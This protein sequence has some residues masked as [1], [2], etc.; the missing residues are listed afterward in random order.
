MRII[1]EKIK[2][3]EYKTISVFI[4][5]KYLAQDRGMRK[6]EDEVQ[7]MLGRSLFIAGSLLLAG[8]FLYE[9]TLGNFLPY[10]MIVTKSFISGLAWIAVVLYLYSFY[11]RRDRTEFTDTLDLHALTELRRKLKARENVKEIEILDFVDHDVL[12][13][14]D[15]ILKL[16]EESIYQDTMLMLVNLPDVKRLLNRVGV[17]IT[18]LRKKIANANIQVEGDKTFQMNKLLY[19]AFVIAE[20]YQFSFIGEWVLF[21][22]LALDEY[23]QVFRELDVQRDTLLAVLEWTKANATAN[24]YRKLWKY[25]SS[26]KPKNTVNRSFTSTYTSVLNQFSEDLTVEMAKGEDRM[27][28]AVSRENEIEQI[29]SNL[30][31]ADRAAVLMIGEAGVG[32]TTILKSLAVKMVVEDVP[33]ELKDK[34]LVVFDFNK[35]INQAKSTNELRDLIAKIFDEVEKSRNVILVIDDLDGLI[36]IK[37]DSAGEIIAV[38]V[39]ALEEK[40]VKLVATCTNSGFVR[41]IKPNQVLADLFDIVQINEPLPEVALQILFDE[42]KN[43]ESKYGKEIQFGAFRSAIDLT[44]RYDTTR[45]LP[46]K[47]LDVLEDACVLAGENNLKY[48]SAKE[49][50]AVVSRDTGMKVGELGASEGEKLQKLEARMHE[51]II[52]QDKAVLE[53]VNAIKRVRAGLTG[54]NKPIASLMFF[55]PTGVGKTE[56]ARTLTDIYFGN[57][58]LLTRLDMSEF[59]ED[60]NVKRLIGYQDGNNFIPGQLTEK[61]RQNPFSLILLDEIEK[62]NPRVL[63]LFLQVLDEGRINDGAGRKVDFKNTII[64]ATSNVGSTQIATLLQSGGNYEE[65]Q[66]IGLSELKKNFRIEFLNRF[67]KLIMFKPLNRLEVEKIASLMLAK[68]QTKLADQGIQ[69]TFSPE[70]VN[71][72]ASMGYSPTYGA[73]EMQ[74]IIQENVENVVADKIVKGE[75]KS[76]DSWKM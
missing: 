14:L 64:I 51:R 48:V 63:D 53:V 45:L 70:F 35:A 49:V 22:K 18:A 74:R 65:V 59:Q 62:A 68:V 50:E 54:G 27:V 29:V 38:M 71:R 39:K 72:M 61:V 23:A 69:I 73:R 47:A 17:D 56:V 67:D 41:S 43:L 2:I 37:D 34:R 9:F 12:N 11:L 3:G 31:Q 58:K 10:E 6:E 46:S 36:N 8:L 66:R 7:I 15:D 42:Q 26:L 60:D 21:L 25:K 40:K 57:E 33:K 1:K 4:D 30:R 28:Y 5:W 32:K 19:Q 13:I 16:P 24:R 75:L 55:G 52:G 20:N 76:G 44:V